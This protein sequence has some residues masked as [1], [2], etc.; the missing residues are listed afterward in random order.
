MHEELLD[1]DTRTVLEQ[2]PPIKYAPVLQHLG[3]LGLEQFKSLYA[4]PTPIYTN[5]IVNHTVLIEQVSAF[6]SP[7][8]RWRAPFFDEHHLHWEKSY[9]SPELHDGDMLPSE[10][11]NL[12]IHTLW[13]PREFHNFVHALTL[14]SE[15]PSLEV[16]QQSVRR[17]RL[18][19]HLFKI[20]SQAIELR[21]RNERLVP[22]PGDDDRLRDPIKKRIIDAG[23]LEQR[24]QEFIGEITEHFRSGMPPDLTNLSS[25]SFEEASDVEPVLIQ[26]RKG[27]SEA[28]VHSTNRRRGRPVRL[29]ID[30]QSV[31]H[32]AKAA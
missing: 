3:R 19:H 31:E 25:L 26:I 13:V 9:Y 29:P 10:F 23:V 16:M 30:Q 5:G 1:A 20:S 12:P 22:L 28:I 6:V 32:A 15:V 27:A 11:R 14:P 2:L 21:E 24:R 18:N 4:I 17:Y 7:E 8:Y